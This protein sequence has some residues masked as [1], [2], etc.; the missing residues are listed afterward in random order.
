MCQ[1]Q[2]WFGLP[3]LRPSCEILASQCL[4]PLSSSGYYYTQLETAVQTQ[5]SLVD[6]GKGLSVKL[7]KGIGPKQLLPVA[8]AMRWGLFSFVSRR[9]CGP[10]SH[11]MSRNHTAKETEKS[12]SKFSFVLQCGPAPVSCSSQ[13]GPLEN[14]GLTPALSSS[15][16]CPKAM[17]RE[18]GSK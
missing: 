1:T 12:V 11:T 17:G 4:T 13:N 3:A 2:E 8:G 6:H 15:P 16:S 10:T 14:G 5:S 18:E 9:G 7:C